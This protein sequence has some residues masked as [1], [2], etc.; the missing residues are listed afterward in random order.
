MYFLQCYYYST[1]GVA[2]VS[3]RN[4]CPIFTTVKAGSITQGH[5]CSII[6][7]SAN[8]LYVECV[9][10][11]PYFTNKS[12]K[13]LHV[14]KLPPHESEAVLDVSYFTSSL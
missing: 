4:H 10:N 2:D 7:F 11:N 3:G 6:H 5:F 14:M 8:N 1:W 12:L 13:T 9:P